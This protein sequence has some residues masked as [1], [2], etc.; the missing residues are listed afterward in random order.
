MS[1]IYP[2]LLQSSNIIN[3][4]A[5]FDIRERR[6]DTASKVK[7]KRTLQIDYIDTIKIKLY[8]TKKQ[9][10]ILLKWLDNCIDIYNH[11]N[12]YIKQ[13]INNNNYKK[14]LNFINIRKQLNKQLKNICNIDNL[15]KH[16][17]DY[18]VKHCVEMYK[19]A[20]S[21]HK[22]ISKFNITDMVKNRRRK[23]LTIEPLSVSKNK[24]SIFLRELGI[25]ESSLPLNN[26]T[27]NSILQYD[28]YKKTFIIISP[29]DISNNNEVNQYRK[30]G[31]DI[32]VRTFLTTYS[33]EAA[34]EIGT[35]N[36]KIIDRLHK[37]IDCIKHSKD[38]K[39]ISEQKYNKLN[40]KY[41]DKLKNII[42]DMHCKSAYFL[43]SQY[44]KIIIGKVST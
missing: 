14:E 30:C 36:N 6:N 10:I 17:A 5:W 2:S 21:N 9:E 35:N 39:I 11:T 18:S 22:N 13:I 44:R 3:S 26:I 32:G 25:I 8:P 38:I 42:T 41:R 16:T 4:N 28:S 19:S 24:N 7:K 31:V 23:N 27:K 20:F 33:S 40:F 1:R 34:Y 43:L 37:H 12:D 15:N 29:K